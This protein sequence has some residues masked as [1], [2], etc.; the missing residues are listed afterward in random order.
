MMAANPSPEPPDPF[1][2][3][4]ESADSYALSHTVGENVEVSFYLGNQ[5]ISFPKPHRR[6]RHRPYGT[7]SLSADEFHA[8]YR[9][10]EDQARR[11]GGGRATNA[12]IASYLNV[13]V[14]TFY[15]YVRLYGR[16]SPT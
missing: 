6:P 15:R 16:P 3:L 11:K 8:R 1:V 7:K 13:S 10:A 5:R 12:A 14:A 4:W 9:L 2:A